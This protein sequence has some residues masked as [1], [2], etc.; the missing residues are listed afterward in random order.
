MVDSISRLDIALR[1][2]LLKQLLD[3][4]HA[5]ATILATYFSHWLPA[6]CPLQSSW[7]AAQ[8]KLRV[9]PALSVRWHLRE[10][11]L[12]AAPA[13]SEGPVSEASRQR[14]RAWGKTC[15]L[16]GPYG[17]VPGI[18]VNIVFGGVAPDVR[19]Q[20]NTTS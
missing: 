4:F 10:A 18:T 12:H 17:L 3:P 9:S 15:H 13:M 7:A 20:G 5:T 8:G 16:A 14:L 1:Y 19:R 11:S 6:N 2:P